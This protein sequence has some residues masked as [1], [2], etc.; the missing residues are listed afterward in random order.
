[1]EL[2]PPPTSRQNRPKSGFAARLFHVLQSAAQNGG[3]ILWEVF[4][5]PGVVDTML[6]Q[7]ALGAEPDSVWQAGVAQIEA[8]VAAWKSMHPEWR[9]PECAP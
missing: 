3:P 5:M 2:T 8:T 9:S 4:G 7:I 1:M 6:Q